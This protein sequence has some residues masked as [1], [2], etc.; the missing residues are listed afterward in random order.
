M[1]FTKG[2][3]L[4]D[5]AKTFAE[6]VL[7]NEMPKG[8]KKYMKLELFPRVHMKVGQGISLNSARCW[9]RKEGFKFISHQKGLY[10]DGHDRPDVVKY[11]QEVFLKTME[12][13]SDR[14]VQYVVGSVEK[15]V[16]KHPSNFVERRVVLCAHDEMTAQA[17]D[18]HVKSWVFED[19]HSLRE[20]GADRGIHQSDVICS[21]VGWLKNASQSLEYGKNY[22]GYWTGE[23]FVKQVSLFLQKAFVS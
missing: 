10:F 8:L 23:L 14:I 17:N 18:S 20:K 6:N 16:E 2:T 22:D 15:E 21:T 19:Q 13:H 3:L 12:I 5:T 7:N 11:R 1:E 4:P 9:L